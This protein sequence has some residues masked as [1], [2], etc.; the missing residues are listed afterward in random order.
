M[1]G[2]SQCSEKWTKPKTAGRGR[3]VVLES[4]LREERDKPTNALYGTWL[5]PGLVGK[6]L[7]SFE[8]KWNWQNE[9][10]DYMSDM[11]TEPNLLSRNNKGVLLLFF[12][13]CRLEFAGVS[14]RMSSLTFMDPKGPHSPAR[15]Q[16]C[17]H[18]V[19][20]LVRFPQFLLFPETKG[21]PQKFQGGRYSSL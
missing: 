10:L 12:S 9:N 1:L 6:V 14:I 18:S 13:G 21:R 3:G 2:A 15:V 16:P 20:S 8:N 7:Q 17:H 4:R 19:L 11:I 5:D